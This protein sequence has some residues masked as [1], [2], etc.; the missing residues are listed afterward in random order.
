MAK[1][2]TR[3]ISDFLN[4]DNKEYALDVIEN[5][6]IPSVIDG[7]KPTARKV[8]YTADTIW[9][10][11]KEPS[12]KVFQLAGRVA[13]DAY[14]HHGDASLSQTITVMGQDFK[15][16]MPL[17]DG[18]GQYGTLRDPKAGAPRYIGSKLSPNFRLLYKDF[19]LL[20]NQVTEGVVVEPKY[21]LPI[22]PTIIVNGTSGI[23]TGF[24]SNILNRDPV[25][26]IDACVAVLKGKKMPQLLP[27]IKQFD[28][29]WVRDDENPNKWHIYGKYEVTNKSTVKI[30][31]ITPNWT[32]EDYEKHL[33]SLKDNGTI[34]DYDDV[35]VK[36]SV[37]YIVKFKRADLEEYVK[38]DKLCDLLK[39]RTSETENLTTLDENNKL[40]IF[41]SVEDIVRYFVAFRLP[42]YGKRKDY[43][44]KQLERECTIIENKIRFIKSIITKKLNINNRPKKDIVA[45]LES[46]KFVAVDGGYDYL[47][48]MPVGTLTKE[49]Y[50]QLQSQLVEKTKKTENARMLE[51]KNMYLDDLKELKKQIS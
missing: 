12:M 49:K 24:A 42:W 41:D 6:A 19:E 32:F 2:E 5:R 7:F 51:P 8:I 40:K 18:K 17:L 20:E 9:K 22:I 3:D 47:L 38:K 26:V 1:I 4:T 33:K 23:A 10:N 28:G 15:N 30:E 31:E 27:W 35:G 14:Y 48:G 39:L 45:D 29:V 44:I 37:A 25:N 46:M 21:F 34:T 43:I 16:S 36:G 13:S 50:G 11:G